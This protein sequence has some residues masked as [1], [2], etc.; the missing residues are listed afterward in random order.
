MAQFTFGGLGGQFL[1]G[2]LLGA[3]WSPCVGPTLG[4]ASLFAAQGRDLASVASVMV[5]FGIGTALP[6]LILGV[7]SRQALAR[8]RGGLAGAG[9]AGRLILGGAALAVGLLILTGVDRETGDRPGGCLP[10]LADRSDHA[11]LEHDRSG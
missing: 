11:V 4:A 6:L 1:L 8:W 7:L 2:L 5:A 3:I 9:R 10:R